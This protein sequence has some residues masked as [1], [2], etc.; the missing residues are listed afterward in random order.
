MAASALFDLQLTWAIIL[1]EIKAMSCASRQ[2][3]LGAVRPVSGPVTLLW[4][5]D[6]RVALQWIAF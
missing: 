1:G 2:V 3:S 5:R 6:Y 4:R